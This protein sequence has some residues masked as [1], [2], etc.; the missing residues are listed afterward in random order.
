VLLVTEYS[1]RDLTVEGDRLDALKGIQATIGKCLDDECLG[2]LWCGNMGQQL[3]WWVSEEEDL[4]YPSERYRRGS[5]PY[6]FSRP[7]RPLFERPT[8]F[9]TPTWS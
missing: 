9:T 2:G 1:R 6:P 3:L 8:I 7:S 4:Y 5:P